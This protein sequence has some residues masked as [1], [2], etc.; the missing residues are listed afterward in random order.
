MLFTRYMSPIISLETVV[1][2]FLDNMSVPHAKRLASKQE[3]PFPVIRFGEKGKASW[4]V[5]VSD[6]SQYI[7][8]QMAIAKQDHEAMT[9]YST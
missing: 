4:M 1:N 3:L 2:D 7:D 6:L 5:S 9:K 8:N